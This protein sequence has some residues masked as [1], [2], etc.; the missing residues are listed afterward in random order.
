MIFTVESHHAGQ[1]DQNENKILHIRSW[2]RVIFAWRNMAA[3]V[4]KLL[5]E[6]LDVF[7]EGIYWIKQVKFQFNSCKASMGKQDL[8]NKS[9]SMILGIL[10]MK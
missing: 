10:V 3:T 2:N 7:I 5:V 4:K 8:H 1:G 9:F 6:R